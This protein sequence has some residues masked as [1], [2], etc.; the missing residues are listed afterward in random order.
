MVHLAKI[1]LHMLGI[2]CTKRPFC[3]FKW[4]CNSTKSGYHAP[5]W[6]RNDITYEV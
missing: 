1:L 3:Y 6:Q 4:A 2:P 5:G